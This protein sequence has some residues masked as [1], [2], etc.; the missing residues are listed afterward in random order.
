MLDWRSCEKGVYPYRFFQHIKY[1][2]ACALL[3]IFAFLCLFC[4][5]SVFYVQLRWGRCCIS[6]NLF[7]LYVYT[8][9]VL[10]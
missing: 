3:Y 10:Y 8:A 6:S 1:K 4:K 5:E 9:V 7:Y 2:L